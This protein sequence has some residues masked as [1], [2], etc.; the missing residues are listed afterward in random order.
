MIWKSH[1]AQDARTLRIR[2]GLLPI[3]LLTISFAYSQGGATYTGPGFT[4][5]DGGA[6]VASSCSTVTVS[7]ITAPN[8]V[9]AVSLNGV[10]HTWLGD[11]EVRVYP[12]GAAPPPSTA[13]P[14]GVITSPPDGR[15]CNLLGNYRF[16]DSAAQSLD[17]AT[18]GCADA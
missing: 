15:S 6:R 4:I 8:T 12:P 10:S 17:A 11:L 13:A 5:T 16:V 14:S 2:I 7:G 3:L 1:W 9:L 18:V